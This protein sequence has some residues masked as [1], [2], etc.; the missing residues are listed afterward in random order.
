MPVGTYTVTMSDGT[1][2]VIVVT[3][4]PAITTMTITATFQAVAGIGAAPPAYGSL[5]KVVSSSTSAA[6]DFTEDC[7][8]FC[9]CDQFEDKKSEE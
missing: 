4:P 6:W 3:P 5:T 9:K 8:E 2:Q 1:V 7:V